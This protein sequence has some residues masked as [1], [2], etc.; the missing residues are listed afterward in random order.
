MATA[1]QSASSREAIL[2][3]LNV[4]R[5]RTGAAGDGLE[6]RF[7]RLLVTQLKNQDPLNPID[8]AQMTSQMAQIS[9]V[10]GIERLNKSLDA[11]MD[12]NAGTQALQ[13]ALL[14]GHGVLVPGRGMKVSDGL[15]IAGFSLSEPAD[16]VTA[17][18]K[19]ANGLTMRA[20]ELGPRAAGTH[21]FQWDGLTD[22]G[23]PVAPGAYTIDLQARRGETALSAQALE[24]GIVTGVMRE[25]ADI[26]LEIGTLGRFGLNDIRQII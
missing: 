22:D 8:N 12:N 15:G 26:S 3:A 16:A 24:L 11:M 14:V 13:A 23:K 10:D 5:E 9:A 21:S 25:G 18:I 6:S 20:L 1:V 19:D 2:S 7:L 17:V 4:S